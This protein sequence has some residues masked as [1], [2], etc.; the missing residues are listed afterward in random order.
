M[1]AV[2]A[3]D[4]T[5]VHYYH[6]PAN[7]GYLVTASV[8][9]LAFPR[10][11]YWLGLWGVHVLLSF[12]VLGV[13]VLGVGWTDLGL[14]AARFSRIYLFPGVNLVALAAAVMREQGNGPRIFHTP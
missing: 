3:D 1:R 10:R 2:E 4:G 8:L 9:L 7:M 12:V 5:T 11:R 14:D 13:F 6:S